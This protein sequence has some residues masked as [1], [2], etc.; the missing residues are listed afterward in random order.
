MED[1]SCKPLEAMTTGKDIS[2]LLDSFV[3]TY[4]H[5]WIKWLGI[6][7]D[8]KKSPDMEAEGGGNVCA[9]S[10][11]KCILGTLKHP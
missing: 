2:T 9:G 10:C 5:L 6:C 7:T 4:G 11:T 1:T 3:T 8:G